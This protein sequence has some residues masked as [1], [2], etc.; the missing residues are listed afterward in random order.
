MAA[1]DLDVVVIGAGQ[2]GLA[3]SHELAA[4]GVAHVVLE[5]SGGVGGSW[6]HRWDSFCLV[7]PNHTVGLP[8][9]PYTGD[10]PHGYL[11]RAGILEH[12]QRYAASFDA[13]VRTG[14]AVSSL[15][16][17]SRG[18]LRLR[19]A[20]GDSIRARHVVV[21]TGAYQRAH[22][23]D[24]VAGLPAGLP[25]LDATQYRSPDGL[26]EGPVLVVGSGQTG[27]Q[28]AEELVLSGRQVFLACGRAPWI[29]RRVEGRDTVDWLL[30]TPF[31]D[32]PVAELPGPA[33]RL[34]ANPQA[35][36][37]DGGHDLHTRTLAALGVQLTGRV[38]GAAGGEVAF[39]DDLAESVE[40]GDARY[41]DVRRAI[42]GSRAARGLPVPAIPDPPPFDPEGALRRLDVRRLGAVLLTAGFR[43]DYR[44][45]IDSPSGFDDLGFP[46]QVDGA[47]T[48]LPGL[49]F[50]GVHF[51]RTR[52]SSLLMG[53][54]QDAAIV[55]AQVAAQRGDPVVAKG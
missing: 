3:A 1:E 51:L 43:P 4:A 2:A 17:S 22:R 54:G 28:L 7:T 12:L 44:S 32:Q 55:A 13:P 50:L 9:G 20:D 24:W 46:R 14:V 6:A 19:T 10:A 25:V 27:C 52:R 5:R 39:A 31:F 21:A 42:Q 18:G 29:L 34:L 16:G 41:E 49:H 26:P 45:W 15:A 40:W 48:V 23:P 36:G 8:G 47:S 33:A 11:A 38:V 53:V 37:A 30:D 35:T